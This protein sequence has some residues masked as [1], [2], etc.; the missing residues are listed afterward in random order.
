MA[1]T[2]A[3][4]KK[5]SAASVSKFPK[6]YVSPKISIEPLNV[7]F[8]RAD[9]IFDGVDHS[10]PSFEARVFLNNDAA[11]PDT[12]TTIE[13]GYAGSFHIFGHGGCYGDDI[14][15]CQIAGPRRPYDPRPGHPLTPARKILI[16]TDALK[17]ARAKGAA[18]T[19]TI[20]PVV[21]DSSPNTDY[22]DILKLDSI[23]IATYV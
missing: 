21:Y 22:S 4:S 18:I 8:M 23:S 11:S 19:V 7:D 3:K 20:V 16:A 12:P 2:R 14:T 6:K 9:I 10:G 5:A 15:H 1:T 13:N 17:L